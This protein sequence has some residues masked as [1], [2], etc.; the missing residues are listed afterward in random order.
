MTSRI[1]AGGIE[2]LGFLI[3]AYSHLKAYGGKAK[4]AAW[5]RSHI[6]QAMYNPLAMMAYDQEEFDLPWELIDNRPQGKYT[7]FAWLMRAASWVRSPSQGNR[8]HM[9]LHYYSR[10]SKDYYYVTGKYLVGLTSQKNVL[11][12]MI[13]EKRR[14]EIAYYIGLRAQATGNYRVAAGWFRIS[15]ETG[16][17]KNGELRWAYNTLYQWCNEDKSLSLIAAE[18][19]AAGHPFLV[20]RSRPQAAKG[21]FIKSWEQPQRVPCAVIAVIFDAF[22]LGAIGLI[23]GR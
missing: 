15:E 12:L 20:Y 18:D 8:L 7:E 1:R 10:D 9:L 4:A 21:A 16:L 22:V 17:V 6:P 23:L 13:N 2:G 14:C 3:D 19:R 5:I 11:A